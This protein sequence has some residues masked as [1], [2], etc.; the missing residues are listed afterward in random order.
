MAGTPTWCRNASCRVKNL[1]RQD[2]AER[3]APRAPAYDV[4]EKLDIK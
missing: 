4:V 2:L 1:S 3:R